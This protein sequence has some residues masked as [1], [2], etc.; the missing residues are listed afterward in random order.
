M[1]IEQWNQSAPKGIRQGI[2]VNVTKR[3]AYR[4]IASLAN[5]LYQESPNAGRDEFYTQDDRTYFSITVMQEPLKCQCCEE[6]IRDSLVVC[7]CCFG[8]NMD[9]G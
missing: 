9:G 5:Q 3:E 8:K 2:M 6:P 1:K 4:L 7:D